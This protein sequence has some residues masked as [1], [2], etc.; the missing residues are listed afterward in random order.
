VVLE[1]GDGDVKSCRRERVMRM[2]EYAEGEVES[3]RR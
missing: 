3:W 2:L 1:N